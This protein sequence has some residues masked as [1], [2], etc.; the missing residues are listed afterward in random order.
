MH[1]RRLAVLAT[2]LGLLV[3]SRPLLAGEGA[4]LIAYKTTA[5]K[6]DS[7]DALLH[8][9][10]SRALIASKIGL[11]ADRL[12]PDIWVYWNFQT[13][14]ETVNRRG[15]DT[16]LVTFVEDRAVGF[17]L[18][19]AEPV[20]RRLA[21]QRRGAREDATAASLQRSSPATPLPAQ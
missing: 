2:A 10:A 12:S 5:P 3:S 17:K 15:Y 21:Q 1:S 14:D 7:F 18:V 8:R 11:P 16:L 13:T 9:G 4:P 6:P 19:S 20:K